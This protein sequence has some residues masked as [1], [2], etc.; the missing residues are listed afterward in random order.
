MQMQISSDEVD[1]GLFKTILGVVPDPTEDITSK[2][3]FLAVKPTDVDSLKTM[4]N[5]YNNRDYLQN[6]VYLNGYV[7][8]DQIQFEVKKMKHKLIEGEDDFV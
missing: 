5:M 7:N 2:L 8:L 1:I 6:K 3:S 4:L